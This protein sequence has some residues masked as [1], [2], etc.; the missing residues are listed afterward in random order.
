MNVKGFKGFRKGL[1]CRDKQ[2]KENEIFEEKVE[3]LEVCEDGMHFCENPLDVLEYYP[4]IS[5][6]RFNPSEYCEVEAV[7]DV[8]SQEDKSCTNRLFVKNKLTYY[9]FVKSCIKF[10]KSKANN[11]MNFDS[12][13]FS[14]SYD[15]N[16][17]IKSNSSVA[18]SSGKESSVEIQHPWSIAS[19]LNE[20][21]TSQTY[22]GY[23]LAV[24]KGFQSIAECQERLS[25]AVTL[26]SR[27]IA[28]TTGINST[29]IANNYSS[30]AQTIGFQSVAVATE[31]N[32]I[33]QVNGP[34]SVAIVVQPNNIAIANNENSIAL[35]LSIDGFAQ[36][37]KGSTLIFNYHHIFERTEEFRM[38]Q[39]DG[40]TVKENTLYRLNREDG[41]LEEVEEIVDES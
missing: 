19:S 23:S 28:Q 41:T 37:I 12:D 16:S 9:D 31:I 17:S 30:L 5:S 3:K 15:K 21:S 22:E 7:G 6:K 40:E 8:V 38:F 10:I 11:L 24:T 20:K 1:I 18:I 26:G 33:A 39:V 35:V 14:F 36:G 27:S 32:S 29:A 34:R 4:F 2:Y 13:V 25:T